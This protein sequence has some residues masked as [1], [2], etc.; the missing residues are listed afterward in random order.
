MSTSRRRADLAALVA[1]ILFGLFTAVGVVA[2]NTG[3]ER[4]VTCTVPGTALVG[5]GAVCE[6][7]GPTTQAVAR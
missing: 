5:Q 2:A 3:G 6:S 4:V 7:N 1:G